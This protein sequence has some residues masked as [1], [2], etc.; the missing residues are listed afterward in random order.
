MLST[1]HGPGKTIICVPRRIITPGARNRST[2]NQMKVERFTGHEKLSVRSCGSTHE[3]SHA[4][5]ESYICR[6]VPTSFVFSLCFS[7]KRNRSPC[8][9]F[10]C[11]PRETLQR[12]LIPV[13]ETDTQPL[14]NDIHSSYP[15]D[16][17]DVQWN[18]IT[19]ITRLLS[20]VAVN[21]TAS[22]PSSTIHLFGHQL[23][24]AFYADDRDEMRAAQR[25]NVATAACPTVRRVPP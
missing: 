17:K 15:T 9:T 4:I 13:D 7:S 2:T 22:L 18:N 10:R 8:R 1:H 11:L 24:G 3:K 5:S 23:V 20:L 16:T 19:I 21:R 6:A 14:G 25:V 12:R